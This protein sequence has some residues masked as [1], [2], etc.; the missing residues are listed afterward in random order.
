MAVFLLNF[1]GLFAPPTPRLGCC[2]K[3]KKKSRAGDDWA[4][5]P[6]TPA[7]DFDRRTDFGIH[8]RD[9]YGSISKKMVSWNIDSRR[10]GSQRIEGVRI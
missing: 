7:L 1:F 9:L 8:K 3:K 6:Q 2:R 5:K 4:P 10:E